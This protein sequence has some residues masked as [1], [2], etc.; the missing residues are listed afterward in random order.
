MFAL[1]SNMFALTFRKMQKTGAKVAK[2][3]CFHS[4]RFAYFCRSFNYVESYDF[5]S[6]DKWFAKLTKIMKFKLLFIF[7]SCFF[8]LAA[9]NC[10]VSS[11]KDDIANELK[12]VEKDIPL[13]Y[14]VTLDKTVKQ[15][16]NKNLPTTFT[17]YEAFIDTAL[18]RRGMP[19]EL[20]YLPYAVSGMQANYSQ[21]DRCGYWALP[22][23]VGMRYG[24]SINESCDERLSVEASTLAA[25]DY[26][27]D[28]QKKYNNWWYSILAYTN[29]PTSLSHTLMQQSSKPELWDFVEHHL[30]PDTQVI[31]DFIACIYLGH[32][33]RLRFS[34]KVKEPSIYKEVVPKKP[35]V[36]EP[37][38]TP[39]KQTPKKTSPSTSL[40]TQKH[41]IKKGE[42][43]SG[44]AAKYHVTV[45]DLKK[46]NHL[47]NDKIREG[48]TLIIK[49]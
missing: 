40:E 17:K 19:L 34:T 41:K 29:S 21:G 23:L 15:L 9:N 6:H 25:L 42:T 28:L 13:P 24:L 8:C 37:V 46:W 43:L 20:R 33:G 26:L 12:S 35:K 3:A 48:Q 30:M 36:A 4:K 16:A 27:N 38:E 18:M 22:S 7:W 2:K 47:K 10:C 11:D 5:V 14:H 31:A 32:Q 1:L 44:I 39:V 49:K 45:A